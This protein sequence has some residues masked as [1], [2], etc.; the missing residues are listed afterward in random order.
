M[1]SY[2]CT[3]PNDALYLYQF[4]E[5]ILKS[6]RVIEQTEFLK[7]NFQRG[8]LA[9]KIVGIVTILNVCTSSDDALYSYHVS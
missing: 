3:L 6:F 1:I 4:H 2:L 5:N 8:I 9:L 7:L